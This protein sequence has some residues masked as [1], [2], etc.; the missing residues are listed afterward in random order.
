MKRN[1]KLITQGAIIAAMYTVLT[2]IAASMGMASGAV[3]VRL[4]EALTVLPYFT[5]SAVPGL[6][7]GCLISNLITGCA[8]WDVVFGS[9]ATLIGAIITYAMRR[10]SK[11]LAPVGPIV[12]NTLIVPFI[13]SYVYNAKESLW[14]L[15]ATVGAGEIISCGILGMIL[16]N[17]LAKYSKKL[18]K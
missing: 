13:I 15:F 12:S 3:Q 11:W 7:L 5:F 16:L 14:F 10:K 9:I 8:I 6:F 18:L 4:S 17:A 1:S 2:L